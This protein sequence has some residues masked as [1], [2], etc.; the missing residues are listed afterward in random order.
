MSMASR[1]AARLPARV[2]N[3]VYDAEKEKRLELSDGSAWSRL[4]GRSAASGKRVTVDSA[5]QLSAVWACVRQTAQVISALPLATYEKRS[6]GSREVISDAFAEVLTVSP[7]ADQTAMEHWEGQVAW[8]LVNGNCYAERTM[9]GARLSAL[10]PIAANCVTPI[11]R[12]SDNELMYEVMDRG[13]PEV[14]PRDKIFHVKGFGFGGDAG[15]SA[16]RFGIDS[17]GTALSAEESAGKLFSNGMQISGVLKAGQTLNPVQRQQ[18]RE[19]LQNYQSSEAAWKV[20]VLEAGLDF[21]PLALNPEDAQMLETRRFAIE[22]ICRWFGVPPIVIGHAGDGQTMWGTG[23][24]QILLAWMNLGLNPLLRRIE[25][26][27]RKDLLPPGQRVGRYVE[28]NREGIL[29]MDSKAKAEFLTKLVSNG[30]ISRN[31][32]R[33]KLNL[34]RREDADDLTAQT[35]MAPLGDLSK[36]RQQ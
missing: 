13:K 16:V 25:A 31:E 30:I 2:R 14:L 4:F 27:V 5:M 32:A 12:K 35:A 1:L 26:R 18:V 11:R 15:L 22:D 10:S 3:A 7:N 34:A 21:Q 20:M 28:F 36:E 6:N 29:Q 8:L 17:L 9:T 33:E 23:V 19:M 24:E